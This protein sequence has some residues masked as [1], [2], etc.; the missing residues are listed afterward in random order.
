L[1]VQASQFKAAPEHT[2]FLAQTPGRQAQGAAQFGQSMTAQV[3]QLD[4]FQVLPDAFIGVQVRGVAGQAFQVKALGC[5]LSEEVFDG[6]P[7]MSGQA[8][9][10]EQKLSRNVPQ[11]M[12][13][14]V[15]GTRKSGLSPRG[16]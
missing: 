5:A 1:D 16:A 9:P 6:L 14:R 4:R 3:T 2:P 10:D 15:R 13:S 12:G 7:M 8:I 11:E